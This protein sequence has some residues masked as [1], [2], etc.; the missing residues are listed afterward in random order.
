MGR[1][2]SDRRERLVTA[3]LACFHE[4]GYART[5]IAHVAE[6]AGLV[7][8]NVFYYFRTKDDLAR[9]VVEEWRRL[10]AFYL[11][12]LDALEDPWKR[13]ESFIDQ[14]A[15]LADIYVAR[16]CPLAGLARDLRQE[17][18]SLAVEAP[19][20]YEVQADWILSQFALTG[21]SEP[22]TAAHTRTFMA[23]Y[24]GAIHLA[25]AQRDPTRFTEETTDLK[26]WLKALRHA[27][28]L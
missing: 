13:L 8:G 4:D 11:G 21:L 20:V 16:G 5:S 26:A 28:L 19:R 27:R 12:P 17:S 10:S 7:Q 24:H 15:A 2:A 25:Y 3:A 9:A 18:A 22:E 6:R 1:R 23:R 14:G